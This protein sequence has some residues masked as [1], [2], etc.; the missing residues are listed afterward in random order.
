[1]PAAL[2]EVFFRGLPGKPEASRAR[3]AIPVAPIL[4]GRQTLRDLPPFPLEGTFPGTRHLLPSFTSWHS[5]PSE[6]GSTHF[7]TPECTQADSFPAQ[8]GAF[9]KTTSSR[10]HQHTCE[11]QC[12]EG[13]EGRCSRREKELPLTGSTA[14]TAPGEG[15]RGWWPAYRFPPPSHTRLSQGYF[16]ERQQQC[17]GC[18]AEPG[19]VGRRHWG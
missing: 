4:A 13:A 12:L 17:T 14:R 15:I 8:A 9:G 18:Q 11:D 10:R 7:S 6:E 3:Y 19:I 16:C 2:P 5:L 1:M